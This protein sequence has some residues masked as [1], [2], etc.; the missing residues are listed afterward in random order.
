VSLRELLE[1]SG[2]GARGARLAR[3]ARLL[4]AG[5]LWLARSRFVEKAG[6]APSRVMTALQP[7]SPAHLFFHSSGSGKPHSSRVTPRTARRR[8]SIEPRAGCPSGPDARRRRDSPQG[9]HLAGLIRERYAGAN[10]PDD[11]HAT[12]PRANAMSGDRHRAI[13]LGVIPILCGAVLSWSDR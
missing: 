2:E 3:C 12:F 13:A 7:Q 5:S 1:I 4:G 9:D 6:Q 8:V 11:P 10:A